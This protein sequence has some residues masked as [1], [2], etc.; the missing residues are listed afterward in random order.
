ME[1]S[2]AIK[3]VEKVLKKI[4]SE[5]SVDNYDG[6]IVKRLESSNILD[7]KKRGHQSHIAITGMQR[8]IF[9][10]IYAN[11]YLECDYDEMD[12]GLKGY[13]TPQIS[14]YLHHENL[15]YLDPLSHIFSNKEKLVYVSVVQSRRKYG[16]KQTQMSVL[17][18][19]SP[20]YVEYRKL[21]REKSFMILLK[22]K[23]KVLYDLY[24]VKQGDGEELLNDL[25]GK[26]FKINTN[27]FFKVDDILRDKRGKDRVVLGLEK[28]DECA[29]IIIDYV[30][31]IDRFSRLI[32]LFKENK[33]NLK[34][35]TFELLNGDYL[36][37]VFVKE[38]TED[39]Q[40]SL[41]SNEKVFIDKDYEINF[42]AKYVKYRL[43]RDWVSSNYSNS[44][45]LENHL[46][47]LIE[48]VNRYYPYELKIYEESGN[49]FLEPLFQKFS[50]KK[51]P[52]IFQ[53]SYAK[54]YITSLLAKPFVILTGNTGT[55]K[56]RI[57]TQF[58]K[59]LETKDVNGENNW[60][61]VSVG[62]DWTDN[63]KVLGFYNPLA[64]ECKGKYEN[65]EILRLV[66][67]ANQN[68]EKPYFIILD[69]MNLSRVELYFADFLSHMELPKSSFVLDGNS[70]EIEYPNNVFIVGTVN[71][72]ETTNMF[73][74]KVLDRANVIEFH[75]E[76][77]SVL[78]MLSH[79]VKMDSV[80]AVNDGTA[81]QFL[82]LAKYIRSDVYYLGEQINIQIKDYFEKIYTIIEEYG[83]EF[84]YRTVND[85][86]RYIVASFILTEDKKNFDLK[87]VI[88]EQLSQKILP[89]IYGDK[90]AIGELLE[91]LEKYCESENLEFSQKKIKY[92]RGKL[93]ICHYASFI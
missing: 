62:A 59:Y 87:G 26:F 1:F 13:F 7:P 48:L 30:Y 45:K 24:T 14:I 22:R 75:P 74:P 71:I 88:D 46:L 36:C 19:D 57:A 16:G 29:R 9:P 69:E 23:E 53:D 39:Y 20:E 72:D 90:K 70:G 25:N 91:R 8:D 60:V 61:L 65:T 55:G 49:W 47:A 12:R 31:N 35:E 38:G 78:S 73:S 15:L 76:K 2:E 42:N 5:I 84:A 85:I 51:L 44:Q 41:N 18:A 81:E 4:G 17:N 32:K 68:K 37:N 52:D 93:A 92:M 89:K 28:S 86:R 83:Y 33:N 21:V 34:I 43:S 82:K 54:K 10:N 56:T 58:A 11:Q 66:E 79:P 63:S 67:R 77:E 80:H 3:H 64:N 40:S 27:T 6:L 50:L